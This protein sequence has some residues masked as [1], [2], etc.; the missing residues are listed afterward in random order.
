MV[1]AVGRDPRLCL[2]QIADVTVAADRERV[3]RERQNAR[4]DAVVDSAADV[5]LTFDADGIIQLANPAA[6]RQFGY[7][8][9]ELVGRNIDILF[10]GQDA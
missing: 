3:L 6:R 2:I 10:P 9:A 1:S 8:A 4:Y 7:T 5:I